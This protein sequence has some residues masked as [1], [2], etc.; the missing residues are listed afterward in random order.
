MGMR[1]LACNIE[2][3]G[4][5][6]GTRLYDTSMCVQWN[7]RITDSMGAGFLSFVERLSLSQRC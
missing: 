7:L 2:K 1:L 3:L 4:I 6:M 5:G